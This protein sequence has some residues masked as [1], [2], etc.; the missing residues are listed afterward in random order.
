MYSAL[1]YSQWNQDRHIRSL[2][3]DAQLYRHRST[4][5]SMLWLP[6]PTMPISRSQDPVS[7]QRKRLQYCPFL[8][9]LL[10]HCLRCCYYRNIRLAHLGRVLWQKSCHRIFSISYKNPLFLLI[11]YTDRL[12]RSI[13]KFKTF[14]SRMACIFKL[15]SFTFL[16]SSL[17][18]RFK[19]VKSYLKHVNF[20]APLPS[21]VWNHRNML[22]C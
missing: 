21:T 13:S 18:P 15:S 20:S 2:H 4:A 11:V 5:D 10:Q 3:S 16:C 6:N 9:Q 19:P 14:P 1:S 8:E 7:V 12:I 22:W 17:P